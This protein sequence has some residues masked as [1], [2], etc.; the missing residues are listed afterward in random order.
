MANIPPI[1]NNNV[2]T[3]GCDIFIP[4]NIINKE[5]KKSNKPAHL[6]DTDKPFEFRKLIILSVAD[7]ENTVIW[8]FIEL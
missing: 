7:L 1:I 6:E 2:F 5:I 4:R 8:S 3:N